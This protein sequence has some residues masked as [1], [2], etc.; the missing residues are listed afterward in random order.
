MKVSPWLKWPI[1]SL[2]CL[3]CL[4]YLKLPWALSNGAS[5]S[6]MILAIYR[7]LSLMNSSFASPKMSGLSVTHSGC[8]H[9]LLPDMHPRNHKSNIPF[10]PQRSSLSK[11]QR[12]QVISAKES[13]VIFFNIY[14]REKKEV[15][16]ASLKSCKLW[17]SNKTKFHP[18]GMPPISSSPDIPSSIRP[19]FG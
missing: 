17:S 10:I 19:E 1:Q 18:N 8:G 14:I 12:I 6:G 3:N 2:I 16:S 9:P 11:L 13:G 15:H 5:A 7:S 4:S